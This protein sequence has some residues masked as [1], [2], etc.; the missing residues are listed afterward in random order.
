M[1]ITTALLLLLC[2]LCMWVVD[3]VRLSEEWPTILAAQLL[4]TLCGILLCMALHRAKATAHLSLLPAV[5]Y[6]AAVG[7]IPY[8]RIHW[9][10]QLIAGVLLLFLY[11]TRDM[12]DRREPND[13][14]FLM[15]VLLCL[16]AIWIPDAVWCIAFLWIV[17][18]LQG[19][20]T[21]RTILASLLGIALVSVYYALTIYIGWAEM[22]DYAQLF[23][24]N[25]C[26]HELPQSV[27]VAIFVMIAA[28]LMVAS[29]AF[30]R[31]LYDLVSTRM[32]LYHVVLLGLLSAPLILMTPTRPD[33]QVLLPL[34][35]SATA[36]IYLLQRESETRGVAL[37]LYLIGASALYLWQVLSL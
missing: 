1:R 13:L 24:R 5:L 19:S 33:S 29:G 22:W 20:F 23:D 3:Y 18:L 21:F 7:V 10:P 9:Q 34:A 12:T 14:V 25:W 27:T 4:T 15:S 8:L 16:I 31:S 2:A 11:T 32:L 36:G 26:S 28:F 6:V 37:L 30:Y 35:L 17:M